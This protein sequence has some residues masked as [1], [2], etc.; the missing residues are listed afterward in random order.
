MLG[1]LDV[2]SDRVG[3]LTAEDQLLLEGL[4]GQIAVAIE[5]RRAEDALRE[6]EEDLNA[7]LEYSPEAIGVVN[8]HTGLFEKVNRTAEQLYGLK[9][10]EL[11]KVGLAQMSPEFQPDG[12][13]SLDAALEEP[14][15]R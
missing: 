9:R 6:R 7:M 2:Q 5:S 14:V 10:D 13:P 1:I 12:R 4:C 8:T 15:R 3:A 11:I